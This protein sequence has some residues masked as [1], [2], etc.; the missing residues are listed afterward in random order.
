M[1]D[2]HHRD[3]EMLPCRRD[4]LPARAPERLG[5]GAPQLAHNCCPWTITE[6]H[7]VLENLNIWRKGDET[8]E[9]LEMP[10]ET[11]GLSTVIE[12]DNNVF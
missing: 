7:R 6:P 8:F 1:S 5:E 9:I 4:G 10:R 11:A 3:M 2:R 12:C